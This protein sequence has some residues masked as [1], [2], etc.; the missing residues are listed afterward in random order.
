MNEDP[1]QEE[2]VE[3]KSILKM[4]SLLSRSRLHTH[5]YNRENPNTRKYCTNKKNKHD[6]VWVK[7]GAQELKFL[8]LK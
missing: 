5:I 4:D 8:N 2:S 3:K 7:K 1:D 6:T